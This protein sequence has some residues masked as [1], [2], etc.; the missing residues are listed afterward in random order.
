MLAG[1]L[2]SWVLSTPAIALASVCAFLT[3]ELVDWAVYTFT[4]RPFSHRVLLSSAL[5]TPQDSIVFLNMVGL[6]SVPS[7]L[8]MTMS[9]MIGAIFVFYFARRREL[10]A[11]RV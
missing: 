4:G 1:G 6:H 5:S 9:K 2:L 11:V 8:M 7:V 3:G 10:A